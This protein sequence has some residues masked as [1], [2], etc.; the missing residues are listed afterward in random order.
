MDA[1]KKQMDIMSDEAS[2]LFD[3][4]HSK[5]LESTNVDAKL[6]SDHDADIKQAI[7]AADEIIGLL[8]AA[9][10]ERG[11]VHHIRSGTLARCG[12][13]CFNVRSYLRRILLKFRL[14]FDD[15]YRGYL[16]VSWN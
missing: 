11:Y 15:S 14:D 13:S 12:A 16:S 6:P 5:Y 4:M 3:K 9:Q 7:A 8:Q 2:T 1:T 10:A